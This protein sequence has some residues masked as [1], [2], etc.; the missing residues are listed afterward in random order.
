MDNKQVDS[1]IEMDD[2]LLPAEKLNES[3]C[4]KINKILTKI[5]FTKLTLYVLGFIMLPLIE[6]F[7]GLG[8]HNKYECN[9][10]LI[11]L[12]TYI[13]IEGL[14]LL[15]SSTILIILV[16][17]TK[18]KCL[19]LIF[20]SLNIFVLF[21]EFAWL[22]IGI[23]AFYKDCYTLKPSYVNNFMWVV[24]IYAIISLIIKTYII[25]K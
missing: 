19:I 24:L 22:I 13:S 16:Y 14:I 15:I 17:S 8:I 20:K 1:Q 3:K 25:Y 11:D 9:T 2:V 18:N 12:A 4:K 21:V 6:I 5:L 7:F 10:T 23:F